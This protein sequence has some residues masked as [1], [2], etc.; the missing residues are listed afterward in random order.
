MRVEP[1]TYAMSSIQYPDGETSS[2]ALRR[3]GSGPPLVMLHGFPLHS[4]TY[5]HLIPPLAERRTC[6]VFDLLGAG[7]SRWQPRDDFSFTAQALSVR[8]ALDA[9]GV[10]TYELVAHD[11]GATVARLL[12]LLEGER[13]RRLVLI[14]TE[15]PG[16]R[17]PWIP[18]YQKLLSVPGSSPFFQWLLR[19]RAFLRSSAGFGGS[20]VDKDLI[21]GEFHAQFLE[22]LT[23]C[24]RRVLG[25]ARYLSGLN[26]PQVDELADKHHA[27]RSPVLLVWGE[28]DPTFPVFHGRRL[29]AQLP[30]CAGFRTIPKTKLF[31][32]EEDPGA[33]LHH[34]GEFLS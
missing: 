34:L 28:D 1:S 31:P 8:R 26:W 11:T 32:H 9:L 12:A 22:P 19:S 23:R 15:V 18:L 7:E 24:R 29:A 25:Y 17:P 30:T 2:I 13:I 16:H 10:G 27:I 5:R 21:D 3:Y 20:F 33:V 6:I 14:N 4:G